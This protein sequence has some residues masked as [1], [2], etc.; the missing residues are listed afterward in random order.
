MMTDKIIIFYYLIRPAVTLWCLVELI[1]ITI[2]NLFCAFILN[3]V[4]YIPYSY[5]IYFYL[6]IICIKNCVEYLYI[7]WLPLNRKTLHDLLFVLLERVCA[8][9]ELNQNTFRHSLETSNWRFTRLI[10]RP[11]WWHEAPP[12]NQ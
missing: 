2:K 10:S 7:N 12:P 3:V 8:E 11:N 6:N 9:Q 4:F 5:H 1:I